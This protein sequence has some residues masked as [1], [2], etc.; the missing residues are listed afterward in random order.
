MDNSFD[1][2][3]KTKQKILNDE[4][5]IRWTYTSNAIEG[6]TVSLGDTAF[7][8]EQG[9]TV[10]GITLKEHNEVVGHAKAVDIV[11]DLVKKETIT[12]KDVFLLH[13]A[14]QTDIIIDIE[15]PIGAYKIMENGRYIIIDGKREYQSYP[16][17]ND[18]EYLMNLWFK[19]FSDIKKQNI[20]LEECIKLYTRSHMGFTSIHP[21]FDGNGRVGRLL[22]NIPMIKNGY[23]PLI[24]DNKKREI[25][26]KL[27]MD[28]NLN[29][30]ELNQNTQQLVEENEYFDTLYEFFQSQYQNSH[31]LFNEIKG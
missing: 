11:Y 2:L 14:I 20:S 18:I 26:M 31:L 27:L 22:A 13:K 24:I 1:G 7:I 23:L 30:K 16:H 12:Q 6:N 9:L 17:P 21:F 4:F 28:Y 8:I 29:A 25:Y 10:S 19:E 5:K 15:C 3:T